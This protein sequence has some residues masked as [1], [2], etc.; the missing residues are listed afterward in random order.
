MHL[1]VAP[2]RAQGLANI[3]P[4]AASVRAS[5]A[6]Q[7]DTYGEAAFREL[8]ARVDPR[9][10][11]RISPGDRQRLCRAREVFEATGKALSDW[12]GESAGAI[13]ESWV[14]VVLEPPRDA[15]YARCDDRLGA[16]SAP[17]PAE[18]MTKPSG[19][20]VGVYDRPSALRSRVS[21]CR[22]RSR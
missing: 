21:L 20:S 22:S 5:V 9:A 3:P 7:Y 12:Q 11:E 10:A 8:L 15:L 17:L 19:K 4:V 1:D 16:S 18:V 13:D 14:A 2:A 6:D